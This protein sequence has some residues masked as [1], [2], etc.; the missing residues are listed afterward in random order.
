LAIVDVVA[1]AGG[2]LELGRAI[3]DQNAQTH[4]GRQPGTAAGA[5]LRDGTVVTGAR[6]ANLHRL[7]RIGFL[8]ALRCAQWDKVAG[9]IPAR[10]RIRQKLISQIGI[11]VAG[12]HQIQ[13]EFADKASADVIACG[14]GGSPGSCRLSLGDGTG[15][16]PR[17]ALQGQIKQAT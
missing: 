12:S 8:L 17:P 9:Q 2:D 4:G 14:H 7:L 5:P 13:G 3:L 6:L 15:R 10:W 11:V 1:P 16:R